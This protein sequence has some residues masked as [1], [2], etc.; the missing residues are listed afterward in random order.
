MQIPND[1]HIKILFVTWDGP[2]VTY[3]ESLFL[4]IFKMLAQRKIFFHVLQFT[5][6]NKIKRQELKDILNEHRITYQSVSVLRRPLSAG[7]LLTTFVGTLY[8]RRAIKNLGVDIVL[9]RSTLPAIASIL[10]LKAFPDVG[11]L[12]DADGLPH[13]ERIDFAGMSSSG[14]AY[15]LLRDFEAL[16]VRRA[17]AVLT[18]SKK[19]IDILVARGGA[20]INPSKFHVVTNGRDEKIFKPILQDGRSNVRHTLGIE[21]DDTPLLVYVGSSMGG[22][23]CG[24]KIFEFFKSVHAKRQDAR[25][26]LISSKDEA[27]L[28]L[29]KH[30][31]LRAF[32]YIKQ[33]PPE[34]VPKY[35]GICDF[36]LVL[37]HQKFSMQAVAAIKL[38]EYLLCGVPVLASSGIGNSDKLITADVGYLL[39]TMLP[40]DIEIAANWFLKTVLPDREGFR[41]RSRDAG[42]KYFT[43]KRCVGVYENVIKSIVTS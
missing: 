21:N 35:L 26:L 13:D 38:G 19:A 24:Q 2:Q 32:C 33:L 10:A 14:I 11:L 4:P 17:N 6:A 30:E 29:S 3:L 18:R 28:L 5:W 37:I 40:D 34:D 43:L 7:S 31:E 20:G 25:L 23:Y 41:Q 16:A 27:N 1:R 22:K 12:F 39:P 9:P 8:I 15:R 36:G 42:L